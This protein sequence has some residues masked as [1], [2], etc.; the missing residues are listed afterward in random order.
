[1]KKQYIFLCKYKY[2]AKEVGDNRKTLKLLISLN[3][4]ES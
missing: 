4:Y 1:M 2:L 3:E